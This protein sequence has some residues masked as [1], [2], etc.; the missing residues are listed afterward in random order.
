MPKWEYRLLDSRALEGGST[1][2]GKT[3]EAV[4]AHLNALGEVGWE[5]ITVSFKDIQRG[6]EFVGL[7][8]RPVA[9]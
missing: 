1:F 8:R 3:R 2:K 6:Y 9:E 4:E 7:A 5:I